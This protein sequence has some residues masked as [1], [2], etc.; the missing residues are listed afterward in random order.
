M[1][2]IV[3]PWK[4]E[5][6]KEA[7]AQSPSPA[8]AREAETAAQ[9]KPAQAKLTLRLA[10]GLIGML[11]ASL[12]AIL[13]QQVTAQAMTDIRG[14]LSIGHDD[15]SWL[16][17]LFEAA[18]VSAMVFAPWFGVTFTLKR[19]AIGAMLATMFFVPPSLKE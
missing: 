19:F 8:A 9:P 5:T 16:T 3:N 10:T 15:G 6:E 2:T 1:N 11:L 12:A 17:V 13:N 4:A 7:L 18:N 14:A